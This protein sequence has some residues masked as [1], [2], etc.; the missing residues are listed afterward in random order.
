[1][2][3]NTEPIRL[4]TRKTS[5]PPWASGHKVRRYNEQLFELSWFCANTYKKK[6]KVYGKWY[7][8]YVKEDEAREFCREF[9][10]EVPE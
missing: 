4:P 10:L 7:K 5:P 3:V 2:A 8:R 6:G 1:M 9:G